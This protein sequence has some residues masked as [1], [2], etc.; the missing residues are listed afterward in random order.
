MAH[1]DSLPP[2][3]FGVILSLRETLA[4]YQFARMNVACIFCLSDIQCHSQTE[5]NFG[6]VPQFYYIL[7]RTCFPDAQ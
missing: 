6:W 3:T 2:R 7:D 5:G 1:F 4:G